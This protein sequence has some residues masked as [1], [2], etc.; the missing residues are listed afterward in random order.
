LLLLSCRGVRAAVRTAITSLAAVSFLAGYWYVRNLFVA[1]R[2]LYPQPVWPGQVSDIV[3][4]EHVWTSTLL[5]NP[6]G[7]KWDLWFEALWRFTGPAHVAGLVLLP[8]ALL[9]LLGTGASVSRRDKTGGN[10]RVAFALM[11]LVAGT[12]YAI[13]PFTVE[14]QPSTLNSIRLG[15]DPMR[16]GLCF[17]TLATIATVVLIS[18]C[19]PRA[20][21]AG[22]RAFPDEP[23]ETCARAQSWLGNLFAWAFWSVFL[24]GVIYQFLVEVRL[25]GGSFSVDRK[26]A[27]CFWITLA[28]AELIFVTGAVL[29]LCRSRHAIAVAVTIALIALHALG[30]GWLSQRWHE[31]FA[32]H[33]DRF[34]A[35][36]I[37]SELE[38]RD[39][40][41]MLLCSVSHRSYPFFGSRRQFRLVEKHWT[42]EQPEPVPNRLAFYAFIRKHRPT[43]V[44][45]VRRSVPWRDLSDV[46]WDEWGA[47][48]EAFPV[49]NAFVR[50]VDHGRL[51]KQVRS[52]GVGGM[53]SGQ[54]W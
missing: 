49:R 39:A 37:F 48:P 12:L 13:T 2:P 47:F 29:V 43:H 45:G 31:G 38:R 14:N 36:D 22:G 15:Y 27:E 20:I 24:A 40:D 41:L 35:T 26:L 6:S 42:S 46:K 34:F 53:E 28:L 50:R 32:S 16:M 11:C 9:W 23:Q 18:D 10:V 3:T 21:G 17:L 7:E 1:G 25:D 8:A 5:G 33:Y 30:A 44:V 52:L 19:L 54:K 4:N 51:A